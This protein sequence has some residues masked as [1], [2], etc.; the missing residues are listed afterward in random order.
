MLQAQTIV[1]ELLEL[2]VKLM[3]DA[4]FHNFFLVGGTSSVLCCF[5]F[6]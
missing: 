6:V 2:L 4:L 5:S 1:P 3:K